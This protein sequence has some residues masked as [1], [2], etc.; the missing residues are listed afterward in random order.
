MPKVA[1]LIVIQLCY[2]DLW[3]F[4][5]QKQSKIEKVIN[6]YQSENKQLTQVV[7]SQTSVKLITFS[8]LDHFQWENGHN[9]LQQSWI[10]IKSQPFP[11]KKLDLSVLSI[12]IGYRINWIISKV[13]ASKIF[14]FIF[15][16]SKELLAPL[17]S[18][19]GTCSVFCHSFSV[20]PGVIVLVCE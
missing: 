15:L 6:F 20:S 5:H 16:A 8:I 7:C 12:W 14:F 13:Q 2:N 4:S 18:K 10:T 17:R 3:P 9:P 1:F 19:I 11:P